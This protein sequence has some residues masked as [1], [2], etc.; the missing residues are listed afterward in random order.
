M[1]SARKWYVDE[2]YNYLISNINSFDTD[3]YVNREYNIKNQ[4]DITYFIGHV[5]SCIYILS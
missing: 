5:I 2:P 1:V 3:I 4:N